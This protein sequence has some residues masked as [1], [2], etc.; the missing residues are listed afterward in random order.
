M[1]FSSDCCKLFCIRC[2]HDLQPSSAQKLHTSCSKIMQVAL[3][4]SPD[5]SLIPLTHRRYRCA[6]GLSIVIL[7]TRQ[8]YQMVLTGIKGD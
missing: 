4:A 5:Q 1:I 8:V 2:V 3:L 6:N 7:E